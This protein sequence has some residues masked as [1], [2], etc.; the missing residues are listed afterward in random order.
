MPVRMQTGRN[1]RRRHAKK[2]ERRQGRRRSTASAGRNERRIR[3]RVSLSE[4]RVHI[5]SG[6]CK[7]SVHKKVQKLE[8]EKERALAVIALDYIGLFLRPRQVGLS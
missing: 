7:G 4:N 2:A 6:K 3:E 8:A 5:V 1:G